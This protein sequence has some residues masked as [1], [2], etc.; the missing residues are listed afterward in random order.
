MPKIQHM[1]QVSNIQTLLSGRPLKDVIAGQAAHRPRDAEELF[2]A[3]SHRLYREQMEQDKVL[4]QQVK[5]GC[6][7]RQGILLYIF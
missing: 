2:L 7:S 5:C 1:S 6:D 3:K 4:S